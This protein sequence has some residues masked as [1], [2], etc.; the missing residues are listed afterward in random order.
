MHQEPR[1][2]SK[3]M[4][5]I[6]NTRRLSKATSICVNP[7]RASHIWTPPREHPETY[8]RL[9]SPSCLDY[10]TAADKAHNHSLIFNNL[11]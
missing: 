6:Y 8:E 1:R 11:H 9:M 2:S 3:Y 10:L 7:T 4:E 5:E